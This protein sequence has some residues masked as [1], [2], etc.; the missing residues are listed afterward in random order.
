VKLIESNGIGI[1]LFQDEIDT[2]DREYMVALAGQ[3][4]S[5]TG[6]SGFTSENLFR[7]IRED[8]VQADGEALA[9]TINTQGIPQFA[10][11]RWGMGAVESG[12]CVEWDTAKPKDRAAEA[13][14]MANAAGA[15][16]AWQEVLRKQGLQLK[17]DEVLARFG[18]P[19]EQMTAT[20][21]AVSETTN[22]EPDGAIDLQEAA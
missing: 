11:S 3:E 20:L 6:G 9:Y 21:A 1:K 8:L 2:S 12:T 13:Q 19:V 15:A 7:T 14:A 5:T 4:V 10:A 18:I 16:K 17:M 22:V